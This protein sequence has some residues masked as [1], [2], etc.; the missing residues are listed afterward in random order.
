[1]Y[2]DYKKTGDSALKPN[3]QTISAVIEA[4]QKS[5]GRDAGERAEAIL[6]W[7]TSVYED[8]KDETLRPNEYSFSS[9]ISAWSKSR[10][11]G[12][13]IRARKVL[14]KMIDLHESGVL[15]ASPNT[16]CYTAVINS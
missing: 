10:K 14:D 1:M 16:H 3:T 9:T 12:K 5:G 4:W 7:M 13:S 8:E 2:Q 11:V 15:A 6:D